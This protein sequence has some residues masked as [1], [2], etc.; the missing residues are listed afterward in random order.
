MTLISPTIDQAKIQ[1][2]ERNF[3]VLA[4]QR[5]SMLSNLPGVEYVAFEGSKHNFPRASK[6]EMQKLQGR[7]PK[8]QYN[9]FDY[10][11]R[12]M[13]KQSFGYSIMFDKNDNLEMMDDPTSTAYQEVMTALNRQKDR[14]IAEA[15]FANILCGDPNSNQSLTSVSAEDDGV[16]TIDATGGLT[17]TLLKSGLIN[18][19]N[20]SVTTGDLMSANLSFIC[21]GTDIGQLLEEAK[22]INN[23]FTASR[24]VDNG[25]ITKILGMNVVALPGS[26]TENI[27]L[28]KTILNESGTTRDCILLAP[29]AIKF[30][31]DNLRID[32]KDNLDGYYRSKAIV[33]SADLGAMRTEGARVQK[34]QTTF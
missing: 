4:E 6:V 34:I 11:N 20:N 18:F 12:Q 28:S 17:Y 29:K 2:W 8:I 19:M 22:F 16:K 14:I 32:I 7:N 9:E 25:Y 31:I 30:T 15:C 26:H 3:I 23:D 24:P 5:D 27:S 13:T 21:A 33:V 10:D 1:S